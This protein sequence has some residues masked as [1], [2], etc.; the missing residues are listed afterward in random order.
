MEE[1][2]Q[3]YY[4]FCQKTYVPIYSKP[5]WMDVVCGEE[6]WN[7]WLYT[8]GEEIFAAMPYYMEKRGKYKYITKALLTQNNGIIFQYPQGAKLIARQSF[9]EEVIDAACEFIANLHLDV[10]EQQYHYSFKNWLPFFWNHYTAITRYTYVLEGLDDLEEVWQRLSSKY[11]KNIKKGYRNAKF[12]EGLD[13]KTFYSEHE[14]VFLK[15]NLL[16]PFSF[17][18]WERI[19]NACIKH[20]AG[21]I[22]YAEGKNGE[23]MSVLFLIWDEV[24]VYH[25]MGGNI[26]EFQNYETYNTLTWEAIKFASKKGL[27]YDFEGSVIKRISKSF[28]E[29]GGEAKSYFRIRKVFN[30]EIIRAET[31]KAILDLEK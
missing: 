22:L 4:Q 8:K 29:F 16:C 12:L 19:Y 25:L 27:N 24:S 13:Y 5:W 14:K 20:D 7:V 31:E 11:R 28:R 23:I 26:P 2:K 1:N 10:Y 15:Q 6:N 17:E 18:Q 3:K 9:E 30:K 21:K